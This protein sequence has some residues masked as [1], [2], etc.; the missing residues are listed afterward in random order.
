MDQVFMPLSTPEERLKHLESNADRIEHES[1]V[2]YFS[3]SELETK[4][5]EF[6]SISIEI[7]SIEEQKKKSDAEFKALLTPIKLDAKKLLLELRTKGEPVTGEVYVIIDHNNN[8]A[9]YYSPD[10]NLIRQRGLYP[11]ERQVT[12]MSVNR[13]GNLTG[14]ND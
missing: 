9:G 12:L 10:G 8:E 6:S 5:E 7:S 13:S 4:K 14:T 1:Y 2:R 3:D 11:K